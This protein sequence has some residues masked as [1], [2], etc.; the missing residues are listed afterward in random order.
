MPRFE[1]IISRI[2]ILHIVAVLI[3]SILMSVGLSW[4]LNY[5]TN[6]IHDKAMQEQAVEVSEHLNAGDQGRIELDLPLNLQGL[7]SQ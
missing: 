1:S 5:A 7:Y 3:T 4:L 6:N 2:V